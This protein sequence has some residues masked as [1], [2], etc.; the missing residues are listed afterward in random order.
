MKKIIC[1][2]AIAI[3]TV[4]TAVAQT[5]VVISDKKGWHKIGQTTVDFSK[6]RDEVKVVGADRFAALIFKVE[7]A[8]ID[9]VELEVYYESGDNQKIKVGYPV[10][11]PGQSKEIDLNGGERSIKKIVFVYKTLPN[12]KDVKANVEIWGLKTNTDEK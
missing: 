11:A 9:L 12:R 2:L 1:I 3:A 7:D 4:N 8:P 6:D 5:K 10:K